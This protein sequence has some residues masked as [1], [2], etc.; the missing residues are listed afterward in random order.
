MRDKVVVVTGANGGLGLEVSLKLA[1]LGAHVVMACRSA[2]RGQRA[3]DRVLAEVP[4]ARVTML[5]LDVSEPSSIREFAVRFGEQVGQLDVLVNNAGIAFVP[6]ARNSLGWESQVA[7]NYLGPF[8]LVGAMLPA[9]RDREGA[10][11]VNV[12]SLAHRL[13]KLDLAKLNVSTSEYRKFGSYARSKVAL[14]CFTRE[15][16]RR[17]RAQHSKIVAV[18][19][20]PGFA[21]TD[22]AMN[23][24]DS[25]LF[26]KVMGGLVRMM[27][28]LIPASGAAEPILHAIAGDVEGGSYHGPGGFLEIS[29]GRPALATMHR[30]AFDEGLALRLWLASEKLTGAS[31]LQPGALRSDELPV[32]ARE[33]A[34]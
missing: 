31:Y 34:S 26:A 1:R 27:A 16:D 21:A 29:G 13:G 4:G 14:L 6:L 25:G 11:I 10:R 22:I 32:H 23:A 12:G 9:F 30:S 28:R 17:L 5:Q 2:E 19:A 7:T 33:H 8:A 24:Y 20:H 18:A 15:L 3:R